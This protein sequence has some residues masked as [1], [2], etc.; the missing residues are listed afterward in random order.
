MFEEI[1]ADVLQKIRLAEIFD[2]EIYGIY[3]KAGG[4]DCIYQPCNPNPVSDQ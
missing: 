1:A 2:T 4:G 3:H